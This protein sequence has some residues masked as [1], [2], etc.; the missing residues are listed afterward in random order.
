METASLTNAKI[1]GVVEVFVDGG[2]SY[3]ISRAWFWDFLIQLLLGAGAIAFGVCFVVYFV[4]WNELKTDVA[5]RA[6]PTLLQP[7]ST[8]MTNMESTMMAKI[9]IQTAQRQCIEG[10]S[11]C[12]LGTFGVYVAPA[13][14]CQLSAEN[15]VVH[16]EDPSGANPLR[17]HTSFNNAGICDDNW[18]YTD[19]YSR[20]NSFYACLSPAQAHIVMM[21]PGNAY[22]NSTCQL[23]SAPY[24]ATNVKMTS[25][26]MCVMKY[27]P[28][29]IMVCAR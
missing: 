13:A 9:V 26:R 3:R 15:T 21:L 1:G 12:P 10:Q 7:A 18:P 29:G 28:E 24:E 2:R 14:W 11:L 22:G 8:T 6:C 19:D 4:S 17:V 27:T 16:L 23:C 25:K 5:A 20:K